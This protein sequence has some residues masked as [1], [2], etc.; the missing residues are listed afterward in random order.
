[1]GVSLKAGMRLRSA[2][3]ATEVVIVRTPADAV[4]LRCGGAPMLPLEAERAGGEPA[5][6]FAGGTVL[7]KRYADPDLGLEVLCTKAGDGSLSVGDRP[8]ALK[9]VTP[10]PASD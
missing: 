8:L 7:G 10:L 4:D 9:T 2:V 6:G 5:P 3:C 1:M